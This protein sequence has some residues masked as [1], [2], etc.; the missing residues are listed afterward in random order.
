MQL[1]ALST[2]LHGLTASRPQTASSSPEAAAPRDGFSAGTAS[3]PI[4]ARPQLATAATEMHCVRLDY[5][6]HSG[7]ETTRVVEPWGLMQHEGRWFL[8]GYCRLREAP[9]LFSV[10]R[11]TVAEPLG[12]PF[13]PPAGFDLRAF[14]YERMALADAPWRVAVWLDLPPGAAEARL[15]RAMAV[16]S[17]EGAGTLLECTTTDLD[18]LAMVLLPLGCALKIRQPVELRAAFRRVAERA[19]AVAAGV[20]PRR[21]HKRSI[22][23]H[24]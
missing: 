8:A 5:R 12:D 21:G 9:R 10:D 13:T 24:L 17:A 18:D 15:P 11:M 14:V 1:Q 20:R 19:M 4:F 3:E 23:L 16:L 22:I 6:A 7:A 2:P